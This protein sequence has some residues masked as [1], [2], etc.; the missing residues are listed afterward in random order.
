MLRLS[1]KIEYALIAVQYIVSN[2][3]RVVS[4]KEIA[5]HYGISFEFLAKTLQ[6]LMRRKYI[7]SQQGVSGGYMLAADPHHIT[8]G[9]IIEAIEGR[10]AIVQCCGGSVEVCD[11]HHKCPIKN[12]MAVIQQRI[13]A[14]LH[15]MTI[16]QLA[17]DTH[18]VVVGNLE[19][20]FERIMPT[21]GSPA[22]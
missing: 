17:G 7:T 9:E 21:N 19:R 8:V 4:A 10:Q 18:L 11:L 12:P 16:A 5:D 2:R 3:G 20:G 14:V 15:S 22:H 1:K 6:L 13:D